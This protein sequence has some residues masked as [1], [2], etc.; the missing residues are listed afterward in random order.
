[1]CGFI[2]PGTLH[3]LDFVDYFFSHGREIFDYF[4]FKYFLKSFLSPYSLSGTPKMQMLVCLKFSQRFLIH[5]HIPKMLLFLHC[6][7]EISLSYDT[8]NNI[9]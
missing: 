3:F 7:E 5:S 6:V 9:R 4:L 8:G 1:M 2:L